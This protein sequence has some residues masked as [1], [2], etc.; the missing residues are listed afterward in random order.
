[1]AGGDGDQ[2]PGEPKG[3]R[4]ATGTQAKVLATQRFYRQGNTSGVR[5]VRGLSPAPAATDARNH[6]L[7]SGDTPAQTS[8]LVRQD[9]GHFTGRSCS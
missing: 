3:R 7:W 5:A 4:H 6:P 8:E 1:M 9:Q 2:V